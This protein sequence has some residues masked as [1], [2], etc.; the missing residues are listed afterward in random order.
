MKVASNFEHW[1]KVWCPN[2]NKPNWVF[3]GDPD[4]VTGSDPYVIRCWACV[5]DFAMFEG[6]GLNDADEDPTNG[7]EKPW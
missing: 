4:D 5:R 7:K 6:D 2:C 1:T 3:G